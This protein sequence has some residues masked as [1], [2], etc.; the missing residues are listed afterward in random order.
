MAQRKIDLIVVHCSDSDH[1]HHDNVATIRQWHTERGFIGDDGKHGTQDDIGYHFIITQDG[2]VHTGRA[3]EHI[4]AHVQGHNKNSLGIVLT[5]RNN[6]SDLQ[7]ISLK[8]LVKMLREKY[9]VAQ[10]KVKGHRD[11][12]PHKSCPNFEVK[13]KAFYA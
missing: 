3:E 1:A 5:G 12:D 8:V 13:E 11:L 9:K 7:F 2:N 10:E 4:G 6:F